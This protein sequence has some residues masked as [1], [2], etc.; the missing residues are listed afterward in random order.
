MTLARTSTLILPACDHSCPKGSP[1]S[2]LTFGPAIRRSEVRREQRH[3]PPEIL[4]TTPESLA[5]LLSHAW[6]AELFANLPLGGR[7]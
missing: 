1:L 6:S 3:D 5:V 7:R 2:A 4:L